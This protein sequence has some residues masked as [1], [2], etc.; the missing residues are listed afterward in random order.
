MILPYELLIEI[1]GFI[2]DEIPTLY[3]CALS[4]RAFRDT[5]IPLLYKR[6][7]VSPP[8]MGLAWQVLEVSLEPF[9]ERRWT[10]RYF[11]HFY[12]W[13]IGYTREKA[14]RNR[15]AAQPYFLR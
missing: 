7:Y 2:D 4:C 6:I 11:W 9:I 3:A 12:L 8:K 1:I 15:K 13:D 10:L 5:A 14:V